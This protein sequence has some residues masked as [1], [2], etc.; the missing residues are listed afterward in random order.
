MFANFTKTPASAYQKATTEKDTVG[1]KTLN[2]FNTLSQ[3]GYVM[4]QG[5]NKPVRLNSLQKP[6]SQVDLIPNES[7]TPAGV[8]LRDRIKRN[9]E[10]KDDFNRR[11][12]LKQLTVDQPQEIYDPESKI[13]SMRYQLMKF[14]CKEHNDYKSMAAIARMA[15]ANNN[16]GRSL[17][18]SA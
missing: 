8:R 4:Q 3:S 13:A 11:L 9:Q 1:T 2:N 7:L 16:K 15:S 12:I 6:I 5:R 17:V 10:K 18:I 14:Q